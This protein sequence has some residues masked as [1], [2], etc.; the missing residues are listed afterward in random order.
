M[1]TPTVFRRPFPEGSTRRYTAILRDATGTPIGSSQVT[2]IT[3]T[4]IDEDSGA[5]VNSRSD[6]DVFNANGGTLDADGNFVMVF[7]ELDTAILGSPVT[8][9]AL[10]SRRAT[11]KVTYASGQENHEV[12][13]FVQNMAQVA[14]A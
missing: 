4:L 11:F 9:G 10:Q 12:I 7:S 1:P 3:L 6:Q 2:A 13:F 5:V 8:D 14:N